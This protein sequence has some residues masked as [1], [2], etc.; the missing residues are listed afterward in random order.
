[1][2][3][4]KLEIL[5]MEEILGGIVSPADSFV[6]LAC[7]ICQSCVMCNS[8][9]VYCTSCVLCK[10]V[11]IKSVITKFNQDLKELYWSP[12]FIIGDVTRHSFSYEKV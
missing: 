11:A 5:Q 4:Y 12:K 6:H 3:S 1:M 2:K 8:S 10:S 7:A 9:C